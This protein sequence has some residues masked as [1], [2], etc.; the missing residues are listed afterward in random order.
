M[1]FRSIIAGSNFINADD[2]ITISEIAFRRGFASGQQNLPRCQMSCLSMTFKRLDDET[3][4]G[5]IKSEAS[6]HQLPLTTTNFQTVMV[7]RDL[8]DR[9]FRVD[10]PGPL[11][12]TTLYLMS[13]PIGT[14]ILGSILLEPTLGAQA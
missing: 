6:K 4:Q 13:G 10:R 12:A 11:A 1:R 5:Q 7:S 14:I 3:Y 2:S 8:G 9:D